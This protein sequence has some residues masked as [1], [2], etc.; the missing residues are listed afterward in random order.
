MDDT[1][2]WVERITQEQREMKDEEIIEPREP[3]EPGDKFI[4]LLRHDLKKLFTISVRT[5]SAFHR[6]GA[7]LTV[8]TSDAEYEKLSAEMG[9][10]ATKQQALEFMLF[11][12]V[13]DAHKLWSLQQ[14]IFI[15]KDWKI[16]SNDGSG[17]ERSMKII[18]LG[19]PPK[20]M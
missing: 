12:S 2:N 16:V 17:E 14:F 8:A 4:V 3:M 5:K 1:M 6:V 19:A 7:A 11:V 13:R 20:T 9:E 10:L 15:R 18:R